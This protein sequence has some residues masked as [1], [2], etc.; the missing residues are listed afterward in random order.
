MTAKPEIWLAAGV[1]TP[2]TKIDA[3]LARLDAIALSVPV[4]RHMVG[5]LNGGRPDFAVW[6]TVIPNLTWSNIAREVRSMQLWDRAGNAAAAAAAAQY[7]RY[8]QLQLRIEC[9]SLEALLAPHTAT[10]QL[11]L[12]G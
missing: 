11:L 1:R 7:C 5:Q 10:P 6:G 2:F 12:G 9:N 3:Q 4:V 8:L